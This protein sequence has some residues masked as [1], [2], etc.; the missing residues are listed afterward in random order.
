MVRAIE[1]RHIKA[2]TVLAEERHFGR[3]AKRLHVSQPTLSRTIASLEGILG[4]DVVDR[5][6]S[7]ITLTEAGQVAV[8]AAHR[9]LDAIASMTPADLRNSPLRLGV[10]NGAGW[11]LIAGVRDSHGRIAG[12]ECELVPVG[13]EDGFDQVVSG[14]LDAGIYYLPLSDSQSVEYEV[15]GLSES[16]AAVAADSQ[17]AIAGRCEVSDIAAGPLLVPAHHRDWNVNFSALLR[18]H[19]HAPPP[20]V[21]VSTIADAA[22]R[23][24]RGEGVLIS[25]GEADLPREKGLAVVPVMGFERVRVALVWAAGGRTAR[26]SALADAL[27]DQSLNSIL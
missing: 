13:L 9:A 17:I 20:V 11:A 19:G 12:V 7:P 23:A 5:S 1:T 16:V 25:A 14:E 18:A 6:A 21:N 15:V 8:R 10:L 24:A 2:L 27:T 22:A 26:V 4:V 3:A